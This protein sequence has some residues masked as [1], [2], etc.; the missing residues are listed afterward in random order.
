MEKSAI[1][2][3]E[4]RKVRHIGWLVKERTGEVSRRRCDVLL[5]VEQQQEQ[6][7]Q[8][9]RKMVVL[10]RMQG[11]KGGERSQQ[12]LIRREP[13]TTALR[14]TKTSNEFETVAAKRL[15]QRR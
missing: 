12:F 4:L 11:A 8:G 10:S 1:R 5:H 13:S 6:L 7:H 9:S 15:V 3:T 2:V 14:S